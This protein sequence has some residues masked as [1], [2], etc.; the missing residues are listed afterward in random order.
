M[1][2]MTHY[3]F[4]VY[5][6]FL[7]LCIG[8][9]FLC[10][11]SFSNLFGYCLSVLLGM[12]LG[13][14]HF[15]RALHHVFFGYRGVENQDNFTNIDNLTKHLNEY[16]DILN[17]ALFGGMFEI[18]FII[19]VIILLIR[20]IS[21]FIYVSY[22]KESKSPEAAFV[23]EITFNLKKTSEVKILITS[24][25]IKF[26]I[27]LITT[28]LYLILIS[29]I[30]SYTIDRYIVCIYPSIVIIFVFTLHR[31]LSIKNISL[32]LHRNIIVCTCAILLISGFMS[33]NI[34]H[35]YL[36]YRDM[37]QQVKENRDLYAIAISSRDFDVNNNIL[38]FV[39]YRAVASIGVADVPNRINELIS[40]KEE[41]NSL[42]IYIAN[43]EDQN[44][45]IEQITQST[46]YRNRYERL[47]RFGRFTAYKFS[48]NI[49]VKIP[50]MSTEYEFNDIFVTRNGTF[51]KGS[52]ISNGQGSGFVVFG[53]YWDIPK[54]IPN[55]VYN[56]TFSYEVLEYT[57]NLVGY[58]DIVYNSGQSVI[59]ENPID[60]DSNF[61]TFYDVELSDMLS[62]EFRAFVH[63]GTQL[64]INSISMEFSG[65]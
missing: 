21:N 8:M 15:P 31:L 48:K 43:R 54:D 33:N 32:D 56:I 28:S 59:A 61:H 20:V 39:N 27:L 17:G 46:P 57:D 13:L 14:L 64:K 29:N 53:P 2:F 18:I 55:G 52:F 25:Y 5:L 1:G 65:V 4:V 51:E 37:L 26:F 34:N 23:A 22:D 11:R 3:Y 24:E 30:V 63:E 40:E 50:F 10:N 62:V 7:S 36:G 60:S 58:F 19:A 42:M 41:S 47:Y 12:V 35:L 6:F 44:A 9:F 49:P 38:E 16:L 45:V